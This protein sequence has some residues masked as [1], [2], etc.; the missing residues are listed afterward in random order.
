[1]A[2]E[3]TCF[4]KKFLTEAGGHLSRV[5]VTPMALFRS[6]YRFDKHHIIKI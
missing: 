2:C 1:M 6:Q 5:A 3:F 4:R